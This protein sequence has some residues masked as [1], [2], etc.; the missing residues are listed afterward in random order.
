[1]GYVV[2]FVG[3]LIIEI[4][5]NWSKS[6]NDEDDQWAVDSDQVRIDETFI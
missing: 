6:F 2:K 5:I 3:Q 4:R 1:M